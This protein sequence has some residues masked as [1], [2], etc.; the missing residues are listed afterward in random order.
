[1]KGDFSRLTFDRDKA[2]TKVMMQQ[3]RVLLD[4]DWNEQAVLLD[5]TVRLLARDL[6]GS[7]G[8]PEETLGFKITPKNR[9][10]V[11]SH[12]RYYV[13]G[14]AVENADD[15][16][17]SQ[18]LGFGVDDVMNEDDFKDAWLAYLDVWEEYV[19]PPQDP[20]MMEVALGGPD[21][22]GR[23]KTMWQVRIWL[24]PKKKAKALDDWKP[25]GTGVMAAMLDG[26]STPAELCVVAPDQQY[27]GL[28]NQLYRV[29]IHRGGLADKA[30]KA[31]LFKWSRDNGALVYPVLD[32]AGTTLELTH[33]GKDKVTGLI[34]GGWVEYVDDFV[35]ARN[36]SGILARVKAIDTDEN[37]LTLE[38]PQDV[39]NMPVFDIARH[40]LLRRWD[41]AGDYS[42]TMGAIPVEETV[43]NPLEDGLKVRFGKAKGTYR[44]GDYWL[45]PAR[46][47]T[48]GI[49][50]PKDPANASLPSEILPHGPQ[51]FYAPLFYTDAAGAK[52]CRFVCKLERKAMSP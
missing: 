47:A 2:Y 45:I 7:H 3:G 32:M 39:T 11:I 6:F 29:E 41:H 46:V 51:H 21:T 30:G 31:A 28:E 15:L 26:A 19:A 4:S 27:R 44:T 35:I 18:Q 40:P 38:L 12:G 10:L 42:K 33:L 48:G 20:D 36:G 13:E 50:W 1:M 37:R 34:E 5:Q 25:T 22:C 23:A 16:L 52:D 8:G 49:Q 24:K 43:D 9:D 14:R 17:F